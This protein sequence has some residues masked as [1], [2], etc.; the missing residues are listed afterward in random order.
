MPHKATHVCDGRR[1]CMLSASICVPQAFLL[2]AQAWDYMSIELILPGMLLWDWKVLQFS[3]FCTVQESENVQ[4]WHQYSLLHNVQVWI[5][6]SHDWLFTATHFSH[7]GAQSH[8]V[9]TKKVERIPTKVQ[10]KTM[11]L[12]EHPNLCSEWHE[13]KN[14]SSAP[15]DFRAGSN[16]KAW[17]L[18]N[19][20]RYCG[21]KHAWQA[22]ICNRTK[23]NAGAAFV[24]ISLFD[25]NK[26]ILT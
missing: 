16:K 15:Q 18:C 21:R 10:R 8:R 3:V 17:W 6:I 13:N 1:N 14:G 26:F 24:C 9:P 12:S 22:I 7:A 2:W 23:N 25:I 20:C 5:K 19:G 4:I 11:W